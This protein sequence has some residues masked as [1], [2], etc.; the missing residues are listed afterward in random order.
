[1]KKHDMIG[2]SVGSNQGSAVGHYTES[3]IGN[4]NVKK[5]IHRAGNND[6]RDRDMDMSPKSS[7]N[8]INFSNHNQAWKNQKY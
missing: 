6:I 3:G 7:K 4:I 1:M 5:S 8:E 2:D